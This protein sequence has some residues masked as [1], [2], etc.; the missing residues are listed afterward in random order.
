MRFHG[1]GGHG[2]QYCSKIV[3]MADGIGRPVRSRMACQAILGSHEKLV[4]CILL[5]GRLSALAVCRQKVQE[6]RQHGQESTLR[7]LYF[8]TEI[9]KKNWLNK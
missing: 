5:M 7:N 1:A 6:A 4:L 8:L 9:I 2:E 3:P